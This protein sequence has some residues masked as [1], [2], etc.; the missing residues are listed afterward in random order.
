MK[1]HARAKKNEQ[2]LPNPNLLAVIV[3]ASIRYS[4]RRS[5]SNPV[6]YV[7][8]YRSISQRRMT[9]NHHPDDDNELEMARLRQVI[10]ASAT[11]T[12]EAKHFQK[13]SP[14]LTTSIKARNRTAPGTD[15]NNDTTNVV[16][17]STSMLSPELLNDYASDEMVVTKAKKKIETG[18]KKARTVLTPQ[19]IKQAATASKKATRKLQ[20]LKDRAVQKQK[21][22]QWYDSL[23]ATA[24]STES[25]Q[26]LSRAADLGKPVTKRQHMQQ[27][28]RKEQAGLT[29]SNAEQT[30][31]Y[32]PKITTTTT[33]SRTMVNH[34]RTDPD[35]TDDDDG[36]CTSVQADDNSNNSKTTA[37]AVE[38]STVAAAP[39]FSPPPR[40]AK[41]GLEAERSKSA[42]FVKLDP[43]KQ[44]MADSNKERFLEQNCTARKKSTP[45]D[46]ES[47]MDR[48]GSLSVEDPAIFDDTA[49]ISDVQKAAPTLTV[50]A[51]VKPTA[52]GVSLASQMMASLTTL[53]KESSVKA[54][55]TA[56]VLDEAKRDI[57]SEEKKTHKQG[58]YVPSKPVEIQTTQSYS[59]V[60]VVES[61]APSTNNRCIRTVQRPQDLDVTRYDLPVA[62]M[63]FEV[64]DAVNNNDVTILCSETGSGKSTQ[65]PQFLYEAGWSHAVVAGDDNHH[66]VGG[67]IGVTQPRRVAAVSTAK[68]VC[69]EMGQGN[70]QT[71]PCPRKKEQGNLV[72]YQTRYETAGLGNQTHIKFM[73]DGILLQEIQTDLLLHKYSVIV[74]DEAHERNL[75]TDVL[76]GLLSVALPLRKQAAQQE[77]TGLLPLKIIIMSATLRVEDFTGNNGLFPSTTTLAVVKVPGRTH[78]VT[79]HHSKV[80][81]L[82]DYGKML[83]QSCEPFLE[84]VSSFVFS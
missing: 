44:K 75:N 40:K 20:Q 39:T 45:D 84:S 55:Q 32:Q 48:K 47:V 56:T 5:K 3:I 2:I 68:R 1:H 67:L 43:K 58:G 71:I 7:S 10:L 23:Q 22:A 79:I 53:K 25:S 51:T 27:L 62:A 4:M 6:K 34:N 61:V 66:G 30:L 13:P 28:L 21:R 31:L 9:N 83:L 69:Y 26:L 52:V 50:T 59:Q 29:L 65:V 41:R 8:N 77:S 63:E 64:M 14:H 74:L 80:T 81:E 33:T 78:P 12:K 38:D 37:V 57:S 19:E 70:G 73:T 46:V 36:D 54:A 76:I 16:D 49:E 17:G 60:K 15:K 24:I 11:P 82:D 72:A 42:A 35:D 18:A